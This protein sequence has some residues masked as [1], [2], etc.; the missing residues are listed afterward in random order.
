MKSFSGH[1][2]SLFCR[3]EG[4]KWIGKV[5]RETLRVARGPKTYGLAEEEERKQLATWF[6]P[7]TLTFLKTAPNNIKHRV[8]NPKAQV[9]KSKT[10][11]NDG[12]MRVK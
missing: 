9:E 7:E 12:V 8:Q 10:E 6:F 5:L 2:M 11:V 4:G 3:A 1:L